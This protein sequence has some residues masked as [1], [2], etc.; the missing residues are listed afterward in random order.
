MNQPIKI[1]IVEDHP[2]MRKGIKSMLED[3][4]ELVFFS[5]AGNGQDFIYSLKKESLPDV[6][7]LD[8]EMP[9]M[10][11]I[12]T[13]EYLKNF[14]PEIKVL[15][16]SM[17]DDESFVMHMASIGVRGYLSKDGNGDEIIMAIQSVVNNGFYFN[18]LINPKTLERLLDHKLISP[19]FANADLSPREKEVICLLCNEHMNKE[20]ADK[21]NISKRTVET[22]RDNIMQKIGAK[23][24]A[25]IVL[26]GFKNNLHRQKIN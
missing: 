23:N 1:S 20:I 16:L 6:V 2:L 5:E 26:Y 8:L 19:L 18:D 25:G 4:P 10:D 22:H 9:V 15:V 17:H 7:I 13:A 24:L 21:L 14:Y 12:Q 11:G 3:Y